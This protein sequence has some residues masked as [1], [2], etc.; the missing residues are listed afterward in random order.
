MRWAPTSTRWWSPPAMRL[1]IPPLTAKSPACKPLAPT[2]CWWRPPP[3]FAAQRI[4]KVHDLDWK[5]L[6]FLSN[7]SI[8]VG[9][10][11]KPAGTENAVGIISAAYMKDPND[12]NW[13][14]DAGMN[15]WRDVMAKYMPGA[16]T[17]D[18][19]AVFAYGV[20]KTMLQVLNQCEGDF[21]R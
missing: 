8:S 7:V 2:C 17:T 13:K 1:P 20:S 5:P 15:E 6:F 21:A 14:S 3:K 9:A 16:D 4:R 19:F 11:L 12:P 10:V 18:F